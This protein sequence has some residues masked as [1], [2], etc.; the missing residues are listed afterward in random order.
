[1]NGAI[2]VQGLT[3]DNSKRGAAAPAGRAGEMGR[4]GAKIGCLKKCDFS[5]D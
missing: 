5:P 4:L 3:G 2:V 1:M